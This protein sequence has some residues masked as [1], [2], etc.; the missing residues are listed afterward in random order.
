MSLSRDT[1]TLAIAVLGAGLGII[2]TWHS[3]RSARVRIRVIP[4]W[5]LTADWTGLSIDVVNLSNFP[6]T[7]TEVGFTLERGLSRLPRRVPIPSSAVM[8]GPT[9]PV[10]L[11]PREA[12]DI[13]FSCE[14]VGSLQIHEAYALTA[15]GE[16]ARGRSGALRQF[17]ARGNKVLG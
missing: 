12:L 15:S 2:N 7:I 5:A 10:L 6:V 11:Q 16:I 3:L 1:I 14:W 8:Q 4:K 9:L 17:C 13:V